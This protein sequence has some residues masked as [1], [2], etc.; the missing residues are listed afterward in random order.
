[1]HQR[2]DEHSSRRPQRRRSALR[3]LAG[4]K[5]HGPRRQVRATLALA[6]VLNW[7]RRSAGYG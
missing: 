7:E 1:V 4:A 5:S 6:I 2:Q 3:L